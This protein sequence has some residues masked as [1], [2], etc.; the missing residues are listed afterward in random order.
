MAIDWIGGEANRHHP[1]LCWEVSDLR[2]FRA[3]VGMLAGLPTIM[4]LCPFAFWF[5][6][7]PHPKKN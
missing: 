1:P 4:K 2:L 3:L 6:W 5:S 7:K